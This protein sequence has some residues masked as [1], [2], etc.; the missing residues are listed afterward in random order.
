MTPA[1]YD[2]IR[3]YLEANYA[4]TTLFFENE[5]TEAALDGQAPWV[6]IEF[7]TSNYRQI[8]IGA[9][10][11]SENRWDED[12][13]FFA[14]VMVP[15]GTGTR[16]AFAYS[17]IIADLFRGTTLMGDLL[18]FDDVTDGFGDSSEDGMWYRVS[19]SIDWRLINAR[20]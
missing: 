1:V 6:L 18:E 9:G 19:V 8:T 13:T 11:Q 20:S 2:A 15:A 3:N 14:H 16:D 12:G 17:A 10:S 5:V 4:S 7:A